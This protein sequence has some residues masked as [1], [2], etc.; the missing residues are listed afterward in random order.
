MHPADS[1]S[2][3]LRTSSLNGD[4]FIPNRSS[5]NK[6]ASTYNL[7]SDNVD[8]MDMDSQE[9]LYQSSLA[10]SLFGGEEG[11]QVEQHKILALKNKAPAPRLGYQNHLKVLYS[12]N[13]S[14][15]KTTR[16]PRHIAPNA[17]KVLDAPGLVDDYYLNLLDWSAQNILSVALGMPIFK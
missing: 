2:T 17:E 5:M 11:Q 1:T 16:P 15:G 12:Q 10:H 13:L 9:K 14:K 6:E 4:R 8:P 7:L 3:P